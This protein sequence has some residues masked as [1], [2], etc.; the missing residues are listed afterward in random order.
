[1]GD[2]TG[3]DNMTAV[4]VRFNKHVYSDKDDSPK[5]ATEVG[6]AL[7]RKQTE[8]DAEDDVEDEEVTLTPTTKKQTQN[9][10]ESDSAAP[11]AAKKSKTEV[12][13][14]ASAEDAE[15]AKNIEVNSS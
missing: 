12:E 9:G 15:A 8:D 1:M 7:K 14:E 10:K 13:A 11:P 3:C 6:V 5:A 4:I 2:G